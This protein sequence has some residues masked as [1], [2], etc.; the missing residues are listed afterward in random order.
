MTTNCNDDLNYASTTT[1]TVDTYTDRSVRAHSKKH[2]IY[3]LREF[4]LKTYFNNSTGTSYLST[5]DVVL[6][7]A[8]GKGDLSWLLKNVDDLQSVVLDPR[9][10]VNHIDKSVE[11]L[12]V[13]PDEC[14]KRAV[15]GLQT[16][17]PIAA[18][19]P[20]LQ[21][22]NYKYQSP[23]H[24]RIFVDQ[25]LV[26]AIQSVL[27]KVTDGMEKWN[28]YWERTSEK[29]SNFVTPT[30]KNDIS[31]DPTTRSTND[32]SITDA[33]KALHL[34]LRARLIVGF[35]PDQATDFCFRLA[36]VL[37]VPV[38]VVPCCVFPSEFPLRRLY[39]YDR[40]DVDSCGVVVEER[41]VEK[42]DDLMQ[43]LL[44]ENP[45]VRTTTLAFPGGTATSRRIALYTPPSAAGIG[46]DEF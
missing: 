42:Y 11:F 36:R 26:D 41:P 21:A 24:L 6:D 39:I 12:R 25:E 35:H 3:V 34:I 13:H 16:H 40:D 9:Q 32:N 8:G 27:D 45:N 43:Y 28:A 20:K 2:R 23:A 1:A 37:Q 18:L 22:K 46:D 44:Q 5:G 15:P 17:Q 30:G 38:C 10:T 14:L 7:I 4:L 19:M 33:A 31:M 29:S